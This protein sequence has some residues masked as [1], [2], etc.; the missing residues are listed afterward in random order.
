MNIQLYCNDNR[1]M[2]KARYNINITILIYCYINIYRNY[3]I[4]YTMK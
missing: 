2:Y 3:T 1:I 4:N